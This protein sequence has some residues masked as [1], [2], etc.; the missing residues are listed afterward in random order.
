[1]VKL[2]KKNETMLLKKNGCQMSTNRPYANVVVKNIYH[3]VTTFAK[4]LENQR[5][6]TY[7]AV[8]KE[9]TIFL[10][11]FK[12]QVVFLLCFSARAQ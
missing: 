8:F 9:N 7:H 12:F 4:S 1:M 3:M 5:L 6:T 10:S 11:S 2:N